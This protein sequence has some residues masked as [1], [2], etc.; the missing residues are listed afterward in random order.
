MRKFVGKRTAS[1]AVILFLAGFILSGTLEP[2]QGQ[3][4]HPGGPLPSF[5]V[6]TINQDKDLAVGAHVSDFV[7]PLFR[8][9]HFFLEGS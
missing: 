7:R 3:L 2:A 9:C 4:L 6:A 1:P 5:E 8:F